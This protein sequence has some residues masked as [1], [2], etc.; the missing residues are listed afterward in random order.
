MTG[1][2]LANLFASRLLVPQC[3]LAAGRPSLTLRHRS[4]A[5]NAIGTASHEFVA[6]R[7]S[8]YLPMHY[9]IVDNGHIHRRR[10]NATTVSRSLEPPELVCQEYVQRFSRCTRSGIAAGPFTAG[11]LHQVDW[12]RE[13]IRSVVEGGFRVITVH[14]RSAPKCSI[15]L[16]NGHISSQNV[17]W[18]MWR[19]L[20]PHRLLSLIL[21][22]TLPV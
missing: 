11:R 15:C 2:A 6:M 13:G 7:R 8:T 18:P 14:M 17:T 22:E 12:K 4:P 5:R 3:W 19:S 21:Q 1:E 10:S 20:C 16:Y 9:P